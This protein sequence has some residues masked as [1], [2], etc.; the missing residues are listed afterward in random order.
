MC[1]LPVFYAVLLILSKYVLGSVPSEQT[2]RRTVS[3]PGT[4]S[5]CKG[6]G[7]LTFKIR[8]KLGTRSSVTLTVRTQLSF[9]V[10]SLHILRASKNT[11]HSQARL[12]GPYSKWYRVF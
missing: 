8:A 7:H 1:R 9:H 12:G 4:T 2:C 6:P 3:K 5:L 10:G 11:D